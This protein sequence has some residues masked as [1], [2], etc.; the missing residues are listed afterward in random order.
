MG[1]PA[2]TPDRS[3]CEIRNWVV[4]GPGWHKGKFFYSPADVRRMADNFTRLSTGPT[5]HVEATAKIGHDPEQR[6]AQ[7]LGFPALGRVTHAGLAPDGTFVVRRLAQVPVGVGAAVNAGL[8]RSGSVELID[9]IPDPN[10]PAVT[11][12]G[13]ILTGVAFLGEEPPALKGLARPRAVFPDGS[14]VPP[15]TDLAPWIRSMAAVSRPDR[16]TAT[17]RDGRTYAAHTIA[18]SEMFS[19]PE[20]SHVRDQ[21]V[22]QLQALGVDATQPPFAG[23]SDDALQQILS[24]L[25]TGDPGATDGLSANPNNLPTGPNGPGVPSATDDSQAL[26]SGWKHFADDPDTPAFAQSMMSAFAECV[27]K[28]TKRIGALE[29]SE[30]SRQKT[31]SASFGDRVS[32]A[33]DA[34]ILRGAITRRQRDTYLTAG[35]AKDRVRTFSAGPHA[36]KTAARVWLEQLNALPP[37]PLFRE[38]LDSPDPGDPLTD[39]WVLRAARHIPQMRPVLDGGKKS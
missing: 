34:A 30:G 14:A 4:F 21:I 15:A 38:E 36:G 33:V 10:D 9:G 25:Q 35:L 3:T 6:F 7:S 37:N 18:F 26:M 5:P 20:V 1:L 32:A 8:L 39:P 2:T 28:L 31:D 12:P 27:G 22:Q 24:A 23:L 17:A 19:P 29:A 13:P 11:I 16:A